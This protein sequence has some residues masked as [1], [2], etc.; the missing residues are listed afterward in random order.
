VEY[1]ELPMLQTIFQDLR[2]GR[3]LCLEDGAAYEALAADPDR[4]QSLF[5]ALGLNLVFHGRGFFYL[6]DESSPRTA[7]RMILFTA[8]LVETLD[9][10]GVNLDEE[11]TQVPIHPA[12]LPHLQH[13]KYSRVMAEVDVTTEEALLKVLE[14]MKRYGLAEPLKD[15]SWRFR[16][17][18]YRL[19]DIL[20]MAG[21]ALKAEEDPVE[22]V[23]PAE[24]I[25]PLVPAEPV[26][27]LVPAEPVVPLVAVE[28]VVPAGPGGPDEAAG[29]SWPETSPETP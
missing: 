5:A 4:Y 1:H 21:R 26:V 25:A 23:E 17:S 28:P 27:P 20:G 16:T 11:L 19:L 15:G 22:P 13:E 7:Q 29:R 6:D 14:A 3:H 12:K 10:Q 2:K 8:I 9:D 18:A 24:S